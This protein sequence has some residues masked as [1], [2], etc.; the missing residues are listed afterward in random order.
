MNTKRHNLTSDADYWNAIREA[1]YCLKNGGLVVF[2]TETVYGLGACATHPEAMTRLREVKQ[3]ADTKPFTVHIGGRS[4]V[5]QFVPELRG[6]ARRFTEKAWPGPLT[7]IFQVDDPAAAPAIRD[8]STAHISAMY[9][10]GSIGIRCPDDH[11][12]ADLLTEAGVPVVAASANPA[13]APPPTDA[14]HAA[15]MLDGQVDMILDAGPCRYAKPSTIVKVDAEDFQLIRE[16]VLDERSLN[17]LAKLNFLL[18]CS[19]NT[20]RSPMAEGLLKTLLASKF[21]YNVHELADKGLFVESAGSGA[22]AGFPASEE[23]I[24]TLAGRGIDISGHRSQPLTVEQINRADYIFTM[25]EGHRRAVLALS[26]GA[27]S[28]VRLVSDQDV[29]DPLGGDVAVYA[30]CADQIDHA[31]QQRLEEIEL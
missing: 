7:L 8:S 18:V 26:P 21:G 17:R 11:V 2:P 31:L 14:D 12:A 15:E 30:A 4:A 9:Y 16:G 27:A 20:C 23:A 29:D 19:G 6:L 10:D 25:T 3:R 24:Q 5:E 28:R 1:A 22:V 13:G